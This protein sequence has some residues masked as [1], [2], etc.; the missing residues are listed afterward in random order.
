MPAKHPREDGIDKA[1]LPLQ[2][3]VC[4]QSA[5][6]QVFRDARVLRDAFLET[7]VGL[8]HAAMAFSCTAL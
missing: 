3:K 2:S 1:E 5:R 7:G 8:S 6:I 4:A